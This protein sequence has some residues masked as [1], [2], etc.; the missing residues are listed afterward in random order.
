VRSR[1]AVL[2][3][4]PPI[5]HPLNEIVDNLNQVTMYLILSF[6]L[7]LSLSCVSLPLYLQACP[8]PSPTM[9]PRSIANRQVI[10][11]QNNLVSPPST[12]FISPSTTTSS[13][14]LTNPYKILPTMRQNM[15]SHGNKRVAAIQIPHSAGLSSR[16]HSYELNEVSPR[17]T[18]TDIKTS[19]FAQNNSLA[20]HRC[21]V[22]P[23][24]LSQH[25]AHLS[26]HLLL[27][28]D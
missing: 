19:V 3:P 22:S 20:F 27:N 5:S 18:F 10:A 16:K 12:S 4:L 28:N 8:Y 25:Y 6:S 9:G 1:L 17:L 7:S 13:K 21:V 24:P 2:H 14:F 23:M 15:G 26:S 11:A